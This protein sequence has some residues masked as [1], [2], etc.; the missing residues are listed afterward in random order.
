MV[1]HAL[2]P[3]RLSERCQHCHSARLHTAFRRRQLRPE[4][5]SHRPENGHHQPAVNCACQRGERARQLGLAL[6]PRWLGVRR[7]RHSLLERGGVR[8]RRQGAPFVASAR[9]ARLLLHAL[10]PPDSG[11]SRPAR[12]P[13]EFTLRAG[14]AGGS[15]RAGRAEQ[16]CQRL[17]EDL[18]RVRSL[19]GIFVGQT[20]FHCYDASAWHYVPCPRRDRAIWVF[21]RPLLLCFAPANARGR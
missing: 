8:I 14:I 7:V 19:L 6:A 17:H 4:G 3:R 20:D 12:P 5:Q 21:L 10:E 15:E 18:V 9:R 16:T 11:H 2:R 1:H 13:A